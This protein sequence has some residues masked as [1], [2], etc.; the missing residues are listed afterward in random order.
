[1]GF[2][3]GPDPKPERRVRQQQVTTRHHQRRAGIAPLRFAFEKM[4]GSAPCPIA[5]ARV[6]Q[7]FS[8]SRQACGFRPK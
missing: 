2:Q 3:R 8:V 6:K 4:R 7:G 5:L 1:M